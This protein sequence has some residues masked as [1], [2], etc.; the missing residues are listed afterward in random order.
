MKEESSAMRH[1]AQ[2]LADE[3]AKTFNAGNAAGLARFYGPDARVVPPGRSALAGA[4]AIC[5]FFANVRAQGFRHYTAELSE[6][7]AKDGLLVASGRWALRGPNGGRP[8]LYRGNWLNLLGQGRA[9]WLIAVQM[10]N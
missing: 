10:W 3:W 4:Q 9:G 6:V 2:T 5:G 1:Q 8:W 7:F